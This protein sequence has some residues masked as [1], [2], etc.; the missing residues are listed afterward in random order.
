M[1]ASSDVEQ[2]IERRLREIDEQLRPLEDLA[3]ERERLSRALEALRP[4]ATARP[5]PGRSGA[6]RSPR[7]TAGS[8]R[9]KRGSNLSAI[10][11][12]VRSHPGATAGQ[13]AEATGIDRG[14]V[15]S[16]VSRLTTS[17]R[18]RRQ[19]LGDGQVGYHPADNG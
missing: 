9:A 3:R 1:S 4:E 15:Y 19:P 11:A 8:R 2:A 13:L 12:H 10:I 16:A 5:A 14:V 7:R 17:G 18:L 6:R